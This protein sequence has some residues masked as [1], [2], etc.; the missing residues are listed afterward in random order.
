MA[1]VCDRRGRQRQIPSQARFWDATFGNGSTFESATFRGLPARMNFDASDASHVHLEDLDLMEGYD[2]RLIPRLRLQ[3]TTWLDWKLV[4]SIGSLQAFTKASYLALVI[5]PIIAA[6]WGPARLAIALYNDAGETLVAQLKTAS[7]ELTRLGQTTDAEAIDSLKAAV[8]R[9]Q[10]HLQTAD[11]NESLPASLLLAF[12]AA[13]SVALAHFLY[14]VSCP[15]LVRDNTP[16]DL[17]DRANR[18]TQEDGE[19]R[20]ERIRRAWTYLR[21]VADRRPHQRNPWLVRVDE[22]M[23]WIPR[24]LKFYDNQS[25]EQNAPPHAEVNTD[26]DAPS[27][28][29]QGPPN[30]EDARTHSSLVT[31]AD[32]RR[33][34]VEEGEKARYDAESFTRRCRAWITAG[35][36]A[37]GLW[38]IL[39]IVLLQCAVVGDADDVWPFQQLNPA[40][41]SPPAAA[42]NAAVIVLLLLTSWLGAFLA[43][44]TGGRFAER[45]NK[46]AQPL[47]ERLAARGSRL[48]ARLRTR[49]RPTP[50]TKAGTP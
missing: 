43:S 2:N 39:V 47:I 49:T 27:L 38:L 29:T 5:V 24:D 7:N 34:A 14:Q 11:I 19:I 25:P 1:P 48:L 31:P 41:R 42:I 35:F 9:L 46:R 30:R 6:M 20:D 18:Q 45:C 13:A 33:I 28:D 40:L 44:D 15:E 4:R 3:R 37:V 21:R 10:T 26:D 8:H 32:R 22:R 16:L 23:I 50:N 17:L 36:Y 12:I